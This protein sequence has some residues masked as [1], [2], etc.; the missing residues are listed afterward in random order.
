VNSAGSDM[1]FRKSRRS[2]V[3]TDLDIL[4]VIASI[5]EDILVL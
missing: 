3:C 4:T 5:L 2:L 1:E